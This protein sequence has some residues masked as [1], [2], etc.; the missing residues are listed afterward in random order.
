M[1]V[2]TGVCAYMIVNR[3]E[4]KEN[5]GGVHNRNLLTSRHRS[6]QIYRQ[7]GFSMSFISN[8]TLTSTDDVRQMCQQAKCWGSAVSEELN[9]GGIGSLFKKRRCFFEKGTAGQ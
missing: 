9:T 3:G 4:S 1:N 8:T 2:H 5:A 6:S 7:K